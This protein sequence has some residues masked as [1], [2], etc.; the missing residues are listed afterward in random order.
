MRWNTQTLSRHRV[1]WRLGPRHSVPFAAL[2]DR[3]VDPRQQ[4]RECPRIDLDVAAPIAGLHPSER[5]RVQPLHQ[6]AV[7]IP[8]PKQQPDLRGSPVDEDV[9]VSRPCGTAEDAIDDRAEP[10]VAPAQ[11][12]RLR[13]EEQPNS[14]WQ[15]QHVSMTLSTARSW[16]G[17]TSPTTRMVR[18]PCASISMT[19]TSSVSLRSTTRTS[20]NAGPGSSI[21]GAA[22]S[23]RPHQYNDDAPT[24]WT[25]ANSEPDCPLASHCVTSLVHSSVDRCF[26]TAPRYTISIVSCGG[27]P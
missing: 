8:V 26:A 13:R 18:P 3:R 23:R 22:R 5:A 6:D 25:R 2:D 10:I 24:P 7:P 4:H 11:V 9:D 19:P 20:V 16:S 27:C 12:G 1:L 14:R 21:S 17:S 15:R